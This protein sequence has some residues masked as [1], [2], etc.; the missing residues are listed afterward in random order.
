MLCVYSWQMSIVIYHSVDSRPD[1]A[2]ANVSLLVNELPRYVQGARHGEC[3][4]QCGSFDDGDDK[5]MAIG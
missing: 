3:F 5:K 2:E 1:T 4:S